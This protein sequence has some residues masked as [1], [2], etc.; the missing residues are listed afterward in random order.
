MTPQ[1]GCSQRIVPR[2]GHP[3]P[4]GAAG[5][6]AHRRQAE[7]CG[8]PGLQNGPRQPSATACVAAELG[9]GGAWDIARLPFVRGLLEVAVLGVMTALTVTSWALR[10]ATRRGWTPITPA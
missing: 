4:R 3:A 9:V 5:S 1:A 8:Q 6:D 7:P 10:P 2:R